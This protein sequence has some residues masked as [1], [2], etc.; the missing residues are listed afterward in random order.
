LAF[1]LALDRDARISTA[2]IS[3]ACIEHRQRLSRVG[4][5]LGTPQA[6]AAH[7]AVRESAS[8]ATVSKVLVRIELAAR[9]GK[10]RD[11]TAKGSA[12]GGLPATNST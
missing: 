8:A 9:R 6:K 5:G 4:S 7:A 2:R 12:E 10:E 11:A 1:G 3:T